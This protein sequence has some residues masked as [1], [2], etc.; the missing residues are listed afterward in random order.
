MKV[1]RASAERVFY[2]VR[3]EPMLGTRQMAVRSYFSGAAEPADTSLA[4][5]PCES[6]TI[7]SSGGT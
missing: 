5:D 4:K 2:V 7:D 3:R 1:A 6:L